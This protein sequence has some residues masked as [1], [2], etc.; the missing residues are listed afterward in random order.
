MLT[1]PAVPACV[2]ATTNTTSIEQ[3]DW[4][5]YEGVRD[6]RMVS[7]T[8]TWSS[9]C[10]GNNTRFGCG[11]IG[12]QLSV[13]VKP[14]DAANLDY[15]RV[16]VVYRSPDDLVD[17]TAIGSYVRTLPSGD[18]EWS[19]AFTV[20]SYQTLVIFDAWYQDGANHTFIDDNQGEFHVVNAGPSYNVVRTEPWLNQLV[21]DE[22]GVHGKLSVQAA[23][24]DYDKQIELVASKD[25]WVTTLHFAL[26]NPG[27]PNKW[28]WT[29]DLSL[30]RERWQMDVDV[31]G[32]AAGFDYAVVYRHGV[33][34]GAR[35]TE[36]WDN[37][38]GANYHV[39]P[40]VTP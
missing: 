20:P 35:T 40:P 26:G 19:V 23:K 16:G 3:H 27:E 33:V 5:Q 7:F 31:P 9:G 12:I 4:A 10:V 11:A 34:N 30:G 14:N 36:F 18:E 28:Y 17:H 29:G 2:D 1:L 15:K 6:T 13:R 37:N 38:N 25:G 21:V 24:L 8:G 22:S 32:A 39:D